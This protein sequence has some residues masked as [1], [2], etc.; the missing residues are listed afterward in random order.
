ME[1]SPTNPITNTLGLMITAQRISRTL[2]RPI[3]FLLRHWRKLTLGLSFDHL[4]ENIPM[5]TTKKHHYFVTFWVIWMVQD[6][7]STFPLTRIWKSPVTEC[8]TLSRDQESSN[9]VQEDRLLGKF[10]NL[11]YLLLCWS[12]SCYYSR[13]PLLVY[14][15]ISICIERL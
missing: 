8:M 13:L 5:P 11:Q 6:I 7:A 15:C 1:R 2:S 9:L 12:G 3:P 4:I 14:F 10:G